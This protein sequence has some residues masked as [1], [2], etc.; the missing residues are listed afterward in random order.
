[1]SDNSNKSDKVLSS[2]EE[3]VNKIENDNSITPVQV[4]EIRLVDYEDPET[5][6]ITAYPGIVLHSKVKNGENGWMVQFDDDPDPWF[7]PNE[8]LLL[9]P[10]Q[11]DNSKESEIKMECDKST[12]N[13]NIDISS[14]N[15]S[16]FSDEEL[17]DKMDASLD[18][19]FIERERLSILDKSNSESDNTSDL[20]EIPSVP[21][22]FDIDSNC[23]SENENELVPMLVEEEDASYEYWSFVGESKEETKKRKSKLKKNKKPRKCQQRTHIPRIVDEK[24]TLSCFVGSKMSHMPCGP[25]GPK[26]SKRDCWK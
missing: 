26:N 18:D 15:P 3:I 25:H 17:S 23:E 20:E 7:V 4:G 21:V 2:K 14:S 8:K 22:V 12:D 1:M 24:R 9:F 10:I 6:I 13:S 11:D 19:D 5:G 16:N